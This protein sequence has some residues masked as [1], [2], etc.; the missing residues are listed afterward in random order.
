LYN[1][2]SDEVFRVLERVRPLQSGEIFLG[3]PHPLGLTHVHG[4]LAEWTDDWYANYPETSSADPRGP[5][6]PPDPAKSLRVLRGGSWVETAAKARSA[7]RLM[8][9]P[10]WRGSNVGFR[11]SFPQPLGHGASF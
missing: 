5:V 2:N 8:D 3:P 7:Y 4:N 9:E 11:L 10:S 6:V 1:G